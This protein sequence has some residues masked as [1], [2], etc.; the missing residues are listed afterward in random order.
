[1]SSG[2]VYL[3][4]WLCSQALGIRR[5][6]PPKAQ[7]SAERDLFCFSTSFSHGRLCPLALA[8]LSAILE[9][10]TMDRGRQCSDLPG[11]HLMCT[12]DPSVYTAGKTGPERGYQD[13][14]TS[15]KGSGQYLSEQETST[16]A[17]RAGFPFTHHALEGTSPPSTSNSLPG[18]PVQELFLLLHSFKDF[19]R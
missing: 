11:L 17:W 3:Q 19:T 6:L 5:Q 10:G 18:L 16:M 9:V 8:G 14:F 7:A 1:M 13:M 12:P 2:W 4:L 15:R